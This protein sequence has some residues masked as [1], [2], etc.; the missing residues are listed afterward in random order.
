M[1]L[2][3][4]RFGLRERVWKGLIDGVKERVRM[5]VFDVVRFGE[6]V[7]VE[8]ESEGGGRGKDRGKV[9]IGIGGG[10]KVLRVRELGEGEVEG[11]DVWVEVGE[12]EGGK[13]RRLNGGEE[14]RVIR[15]GREVKDLVRFGVRGF[16]V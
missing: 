16:R 10:V 4:E 15:R 3:L 5:R 6:G 1:K 8:I 13:K 9:E 12:E 11:R 7:G 2:N 14:G